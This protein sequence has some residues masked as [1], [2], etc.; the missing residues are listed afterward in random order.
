[1][2]QKRL[3]LFIIFAVA[4]ALLYKFYVHI[5]MQEHN[6]KDDKRYDTNTNYRY[7]N[8][9]KDKNDVFSFVHIQ[10]TGGTT[11][12][13]HL[14]TNMIDSGCECE[15]Q[16][17]PSCNCYRKHLREVWLICR[18]N[19][20][21]WP[22]GLH[23]DFTSLRECAPNFMNRNYEK[24]SRRYFYGTILRQPVH[25]FFSEFRHRQRGA[26]WE[27]AVTYCNGALLTDQNP[28]CFEG[29]TWHDFTLEEFLSCSSNYGINRQT[30]MLSDISEVGCNFSDI[31]SSKEKK[32]RLLE[33][34]K[35]N[36]NSI[37]FFG[38]LEYPMESQFVFEKTF[39]LK[40][41]V[42]FQK[43]ETGFALEFLKNF[44]ITEDIYL[45]VAQVNDLDQRLY[46]YAKN[47]FF[48]RY[49]YFVKKY[50]TPQYRKPRH[51]T[52]F[53]FPESKLERMKK[54]L[55]KSKIKELKKLKKRSEEVNLLRKR[56]I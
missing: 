20:P 38:L 46:N 47:V 56:K 3:I 11:M 33:L 26:S 35:K 36:I 29:G 50:G 41:N 42:P 39:N 32:E 1:M 5:D 6:L 28:N 55:P 52:R 19:I 51:E 48:D 2:T 44:T 9:D 14:V 37:S 21:K 8:F 45:K 34:A 54:N 7:I 22:C 24:H 30:W 12:E 40:F 4:I 13:N 31:M 10:K 25:R 17:R 53:D 18:Y 16:K 43:W 27:G 49:K 23:P 15:E